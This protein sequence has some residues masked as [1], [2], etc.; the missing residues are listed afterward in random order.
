MNVEIEAE[1]NY[2]KNPADPHITERQAKLKGMIKELEGLRA[3]ERPRIVKQLLQDKRDDLRMQIMKQETKIASLHRK[4]DQWDADFKRLKASVLDMTN[5]DINIEDVNNSMAYL[6]KL[7]GGLETEEEGLNILLKVPTKIKVLEDAYISPAAGPSRL[8][9]TALAGVAGFLAVCFMISWREFHARKIETVEEVIQGLGMK[10]VGAI[11]TL[12]RR[13]FRSRAK[14]GDYSQHIFVESIETTRTMLLEAARAESNGQGDAAA[15]PQVVMVTS[16][17]PAK[18][19][20]RCPA[21]WLSASPRSAI[22][23]C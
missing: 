5:K 22:R 11:P 21:T 3:K 6:V 14:K 4:R 13:W 9:A 8:M 18:A 17:R 16:T 1:K 7:V 10:L 15:H 23:H 12:P 2:W 19:R 20:L